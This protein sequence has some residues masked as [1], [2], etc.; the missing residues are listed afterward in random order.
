[1]Y[2]LSCSVF[3]SLCYHWSG[4]PFPPP[5]DLPNLGIEPRSSCIAHGF[6]VYS[7]VCKNIYTTIEME[8]GIYRRRREGGVGKIGKGD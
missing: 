7:R 1:M 2:V 5:E 4:L 6:Y 3:N 8:V